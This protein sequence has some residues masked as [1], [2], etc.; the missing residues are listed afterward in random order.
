MFRPGTL[1][2]ILYLGNALAF[3]NHSDAGMLDIFEASKLYMPKS[4]ENQ[5]KMNNGFELE[6]RRARRDLDLGEW[7]REQQKGIP[8]EV[9]DLG[10]RQR[11][12]CLEAPDTMVLRVV[13]FDERLDGAKS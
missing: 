1:F 9:V 8:I 4:G 10:Q 6:G 2:F 5:S 12:R 13:R 3:P 11:F 7:D